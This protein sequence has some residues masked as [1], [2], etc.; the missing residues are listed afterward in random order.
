MTPSNATTSNVLFDDHQL[1]RGCVK[2]ELAIHDPV[3]VSISDECICRWLFY[4]AKDIQGVSFPS[5]KIFDPK[6]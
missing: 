3:N 2:S 1:E 5:E 6:E 4:R